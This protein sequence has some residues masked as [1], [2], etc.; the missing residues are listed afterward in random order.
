MLLLAQGSPGPARSRPQAPPDF[1]LPVYFETLKTGERWLPQ[2]FEYDLSDPSGEKLIVGNAV[3][4]LN[5]LS[6]RYKKLKEFDPQKTLDISEEEREKP[7]L[8]IQL[9]E[10]LWKPGVLEFVSRDGKILWSYELTS[11]NLEAW[12]EKIE[13]W[14]KSFKG[15]SESSE[16][17][18]SA[19]GIFEPV[20]EGLPLVG[21]RNF[22]FCVSSKSP[23]GHN[24]ICSRR[25]GSQGRGIHLK[26]GRMKFSGAPRVLIKNEEAPLK[27]SLEVSSELPLFFYAEL[28]SG[29]T[30]EFV[31]RAIYPQFVDMSQLG[32]TPNI[33]VIGFG[34]PPNQPYKILNPDP[35]TGLVDLFGFQPTIGDL[36]KFWSTIV[37]K[38]SPLLHFEGES[39]GLFKQPLDFSEVPRSELRPYLHKNT[40][41]G[42]YRHG[43]YVKGYRDPRVRVA[44]KEI[45]VRSVKNEP[46]VFEWTFKADK[47]GALNK[48][49]VDLLYK[50]HKA[51]AY[52]ELYRGYANEL[53]ARLSA[54]AGTGQPLLMSEAAYNH[55]FE[56]VLGWQ[57]PLFSKQRW[58]VSAR[59]FRSVTKLSVGG[60]D[61]AD[62]VV[63]NTDLKYRF[64]PGLW[65]REESMG[66]MTSYQNLSFG[67][68]KTGMA[69]VGW[70]WARSMPRSIDR[71]F[72]Y[73]PFMDY[74]KWVDMELIYYPVPLGSNASLGGN[75]AVNFHGQVLWREY[76]FGEAGFGLKRY[77]VKNNSI[78]KKAELNVFYGT[79]GL[80]FK[81]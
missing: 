40:L 26:M 44:S 28:S 47:K 80:G 46:G 9:P 30:Y 61:K 20:K 79:L 34:P 55:W 32:N 73:L 70:W 7:I 74:P 63:W 14:K 72:S 39:G 75:L 42:T 50:N 8:L 51:Q 52:Y 66:L 18:R 21:N 37:Q 69:G 31:S 62:L 67:E 24:K 41:P 68:I 56:N 38:T 6:F 29:E 23:Q 49:H 48:A 81:F 43:A 53:S 17:L 1:N 19:F 3:V 76:F 11:K 60:G 33:Q 22:R 13:G 35:E 27:G 65:T 10:G 54:V 71:I 78:N 59:Y 57:S 25:Y 64:T 12:R 16:L 5:Q 58:G 15:Q 45:S 2:F 36:R 77:S 4:D